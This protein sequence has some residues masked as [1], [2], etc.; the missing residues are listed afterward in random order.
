MASNQVTEAAECSRTV[1]DSERPGQYS[2]STA[3][4][5]RKADVTLLSAVAIMATTTSSSRTNG[6]VGTVS[7]QSGH[8]RSR[9]PDGAPTLKGLEEK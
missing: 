1:M 7:A 2:P 4:F 3:C 5:S 6:P 9:L 8:P